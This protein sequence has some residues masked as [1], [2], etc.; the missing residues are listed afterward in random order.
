MRLGYASTMQAALPVLLFA[1]TFSLALGLVLP[2]ISVERLF[3]LSD[4][5]SLVVMLLGL[6]SGGDRLLAVL[7]GMFSMVFPTLKLVMLH[8]AAYGGEG[9]SRRIPAWFRVLANWSMLDV[10][11]VALLIFAVRTSG[12]ATAV[13]KPGLWFFA[14]SAVL[15]ACASGLAGRRA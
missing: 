9:W 1:A 13:T 2:L 7:V 11:L 15:T 14:A 4:E 12:L 8:L 3:V 5:P 10:V 6:W